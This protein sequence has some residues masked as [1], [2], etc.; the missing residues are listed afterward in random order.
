MREGNISAAYECI[1]DRNCFPSICGRICSAPCE[2]A[3]VLAKEQNPIG[4]RALERFVADFGKTKMIRKTGAGST[5]IA[6]VGGGPAGLTAA[7]DLLNRSYSVT[8]FESFDRLGGVLRYGVPEFRIPK[9]ILDG[10]INEIVAAGLE[11]KTNFIVG[12]TVSLGELFASGYAAVLLATGAGIPKFSD[13][14]G[15]NSGGVYYGEEFLMR[16]NLIRTNIFN[17]HLPD[18]SVGERIA[19]VGSGNTALD[20]ARAARRLGLEVHLLFRRTEDE[21]RVRDV[22]KQYG[23]EEGIQLHSMTKPIEIISGKEGQVIGIKSIR[24]D[25]ADLDN[26][27]RWELTAVPKSEFVL[28]VDNVVIAV[29]HQ[30]NSYIAVVEPEIRLNADGTIWTDTVTGMTSKNKVFACG[31]VA[32]NSG[33]VINAIRGG[34]LIAKKIDEYLNGK[35]K[36]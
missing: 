27:G 33:P 8:L 31:N 19:V 4:I 9:R 21:M 14:K 23:I 36:S 13:I 32:T 25:Y 12:K 20:C 29:G 34:K 1:K 11:A 35:D 22:E 18:F 5:K 15:A 30:P 26:T 24:M 3:C 10:D 7:Y 16:V 6:I 17:R 2:K 28:D